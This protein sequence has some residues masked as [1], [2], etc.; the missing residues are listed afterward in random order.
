MGIYEFDQHFKNGNMKI[1]AMNFP[2]SSSCQ[3]LHYPDYSSGAG[4]PESFILCKPGLNFSTRH[5]TMP[6]KKSSYVRRKLFHNRHSCP[7]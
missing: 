6:G 7:A 5:W 4:T 3:F 1:K 2:G